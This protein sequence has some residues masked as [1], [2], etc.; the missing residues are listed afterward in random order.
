MVVTNIQGAVTSAPPALLTM[1][2]SLAFTSAPQSRFETVATTLPFPRQ[3]IIAPCSNGSSTARTSRAPLAAALD[4][5]NIQASNAGTYSIIASNASGA[6]T[7]FATLAVAPGLIPLQSTNLIVARIGDGAQGLSGN[8]GNTIYL[9]QI[10]TN[11]AYVSTLMVPNSGPPSLIVPGTGDGIYE[12]VLTLSANQEFINFTGYNVSYPYGGSDVTAGGVTIRGIGAVNGLG[13]YTLALT[14][15]GLYSG[16]NHFI[17][18]AASTDGLTNFWTTGEASGAGIKY[19]A[20]GLDANGQNIPALGGGPLARGSRVF[21][22]APFVLQTRKTTR[23]IRDQ[24]LQR[25]TTS[26]AA[27]ALLFPLSNT[28]DPNDFAISPDGNTV[29][30]ADDNTVNGNAG[31]GI[32]RWDFN[33]VQ[34]NLS[35]VLGT[36]TNSSVGA[37]GLTVDFNDFG[38]DGAA[39]SA[40]SFTPPLRIERKSADSHC[41]HRRRFSATRVN[42]GW[43]QPDA[44][45]S[46]LWPTRGRADPAAAAE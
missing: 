9:D 3:S 11:G 26:T 6:F 13:Y 28:A 29:Y 36:G 18:S 31:G 25:D 12:G 15:I 44:A 10:A 40:P 35:Y 22:E 19:I 27:T 30:I 38:G 45:G 4:F 41:R 37:R 5:T 20:P 23:T 34:W 16:G 32:E 17:H 21:L 7:N 24:L 46:S 1:L 43:S 39:G 2:P 33:Q 14:N 8:T 42:V